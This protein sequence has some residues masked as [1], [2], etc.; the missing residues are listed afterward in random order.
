MNRKT[1]WLL[2][3]LTF[4]TVAAFAQ[5]REYRDPRSFPF[6]E[7]VQEPAAVIVTER[8]TNG[9]G[10]H[11][12]GTND[13]L[14][15]AQELLGRPTDTAVT[16]NVAAVEDVEAYFEYGIE[17]GDYS[18]R[19]GSIQFP[20]GESTHVLIDGLEPNTRY[21]YRMRY[22][23]PESSSFKAR[24]E[25]SFHT[26]R[27]PGSTFTYVVQFDPHMLQTNDPEAYKLSLNKMLADNPDFMLDLGDT[28]FIDRYAREGP[29]TESQITGRV[30]LM[31]SY[32][33]I[34][35]HSAP[36]FLVN[37]N[38]EGEWG[39]HLDGTAE[40]LAVLGTLGR[41][42]YFPNPEPNGFYSGDTNKEEFIGLRQA[43]YAFEWGDA[44]FVALDP[45]WYQPEPPELAGDWS[46]TLGRAQ[47][48][49]LKTTLENSDAEFKFVFSHNL[50]GGLNMRGQM[51][52]GIETVKYKEMG[53][54]NLDGSWGFDEARPGWAMPIHQLLVA[55]N[56]TIYFH[57]HDHLYVKQD[58]DGIVYQEG[59]V[60][61]RGGLYDA[62]NSAKNYNYSHGTVVGGSGY[63]RVQVSP[64]DVKVDF[65]Q[66]YLPSEEDA[67][68]KD[69]MVAHSYTIK[70]D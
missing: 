11:P 14:F 50:I 68:H 43:Y 26:Q 28:F 62:T 47:Y 30:Q 24:A 32:F 21:Y 63:L 9:Y 57:G 54:Y 34:V 23:E 27:P 22:M 58:L 29:V 36:L 66:T 3:A 61:A 25:H 13:P 20:A 35:N 1:S 64:D 55:H 37:G 42:E 10:N 69:G 8:S 33:D 67:T 60:P 15:V 41:K 39:R 19:T 70:A 12:R 18:G 65:V 52:G 45:Y 56:A 44:L 49:W 4:V 53:G 17:P 7:A 31:R 40:N 5:Q 46:V 59:P 48:E 2:A 6:N 16:I 51:R 38:H